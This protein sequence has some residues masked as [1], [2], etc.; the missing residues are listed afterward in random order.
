MRKV[1]GF[2]M[3]FCVVTFLVMDVLAASISET[4]THII[5]YNDYVKFAISKNNGAIS[6]FVLIG[7]GEE[8]V[9]TPISFA[10]YYDGSTYL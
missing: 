3:I 6:S 4:L 1:L 5:L 2:L 7:T 9:S 8:L 10:Y